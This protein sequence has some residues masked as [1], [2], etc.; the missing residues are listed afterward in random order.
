MEMMFCLSRSR[1]SYAEA[2]SR[3]TTDSVRR[4]D[5]SETTGS[6]VDAKKSKEE[7]RKEEGA[8]VHEYALVTSTHTHARARTHTLPLSPHT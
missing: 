6:V 4:K 8:D 2:T 1:Q 5:A 3:N 7:R